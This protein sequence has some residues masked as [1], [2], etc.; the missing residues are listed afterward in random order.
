MVI[1]D[2]KGFKGQ[3]CES[4]ASLSLLEHTGFTMSES[5]FL[6]LG[7]GFKLYKKPKTGCEFVSPP[8]LPLRLFRF[9][10]QVLHTGRISVSYI[11]T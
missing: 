8:F 1:K 11:L 6:G 4:T 9:Y 10:P 5:K 2:F 7:Q 3:H